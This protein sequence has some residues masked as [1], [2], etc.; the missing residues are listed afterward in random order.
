MMGKVYQ[1]LVRYIYF[2]TLSIFTR[3]YLINRMHGAMNHFG[4]IQGEEAGKSPQRALTAE[5]TQDS[6]KMIV[7]QG[8]RVFLPDR[9]LRSQGEIAGDIRLA[10][11][12]SVRQKYAA[13]PRIL[14]MR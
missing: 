12:P 5:S 8:L 4:Q 13:T 10:I 6:T 7:A 11:A 9:A 1:T 2:A 3:S 14:F